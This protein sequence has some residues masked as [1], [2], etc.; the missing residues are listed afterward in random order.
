MDSQ[1]QKGI[2]VI[3]A[4]A[5]DLR[6]EIELSD[7]ELEHVVGGLERPWSPD[8]KVLRTVAHENPVVVPQA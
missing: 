4:H 2:D 6:N 8:S 3:G 5:V 7:D 1:V